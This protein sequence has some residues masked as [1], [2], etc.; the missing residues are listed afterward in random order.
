[1]SFSPASVLQP[2]SRRRSRLSFSRRRGSTMIDLRRS[3]APRRRRR[4]FA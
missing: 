3:Q 4:L 1:M 2:V